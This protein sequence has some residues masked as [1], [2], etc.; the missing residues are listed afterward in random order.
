MTQQ[1]EK[2]T[3]E[4][5]ENINKIKEYLGWELEFEVNGQ[6]YVTHNKSD[7]IISEDM[8]KQL[9]AKLEQLGLYEAEEYNNQQQQIKAY[10]APT[11]RK[12]NKSG[13]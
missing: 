9:I 2:T 5:Q 4:Q 7:C 12:T 1:T 3:E 8:M 11:S 6:Y 10:H 13:N